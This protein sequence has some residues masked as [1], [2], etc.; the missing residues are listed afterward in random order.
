MSRETCDHILQDRPA[1]EFIAPL[2][3]YLASD[4]GEN[5]NGAVLGSAGGK[6]S[7]YGMSAEIRSI[8]KD[9]R[10]NGPWTMD[11]MRRLIPKTIEPLCFPVKA[12]NPDLG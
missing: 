7:V 12:P 3:M 2:V 5:I 1:P 6:I 9:S 8:Y 10:K 4:Y 11:E